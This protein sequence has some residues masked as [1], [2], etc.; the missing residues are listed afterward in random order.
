MNLLRINQLGLLCAAFVLVLGCEPPTENEFSTFDEMS[1]ELAMD[2]TAGGSWG[3]TPSGSLIFVETERLCEETRVTLQPG[4]SVTPTE[5]GD[6]FVIYSATKGAS[7]TLIC[8]C[9]VGS[10]SECRPLWQKKTG[11]VCA[12]S[13]GCSKCTK[14]IKKNGAE[15]LVE[16]V[17][18]TQSGSKKQTTSDTPEEEEQKEVISDTDGLWDSSIS[19]AIMAIEMAS[20]PADETVNTCLDGPESD[21]AFEE[22][23][24]DLFATVYGDAGLDYAMEEWHPELTPDLSF[25]KVYVEN[26]PVVIPVPRNLI[27]DSMNM[28]SKPKSCTCL[29]KETPEPKDTVKGTKKSVSSKL[30]KLIE[31]NFSAKGG[32][33]CKLTSTFGYYSCDKKDSCKTSC[34]MEF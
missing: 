29:P 28:V 1:G 15:V 16:S 19:T 11:M 17:A 4:D 14:I 33:T 26:R 9:T 20:I 34:A 23:R 8:D 18:N 2:E 22:A 21:M 13:R 12:M 24:E 32:P 6:G 3:L 27:T 25:V 30:K 5:E 7:Q 10:D 31:A